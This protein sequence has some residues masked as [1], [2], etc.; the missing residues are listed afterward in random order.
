MDFIVL[1]S[2]KMFVDGVIV[3]WMLKVYLCEVKVFVVIVVDYDIC[4][5]VFFWEFME[6]E[7]EVFKYGVVDSD[8][9]GIDGFF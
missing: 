2:G 9:L 7:L 3:M 1:D 5:N 4:M 6:C 8:F